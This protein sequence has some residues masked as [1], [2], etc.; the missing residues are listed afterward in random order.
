MRA[1]SRRR[2][3]ERQAQR[4]GEF[5]SLDFQLWG[6]EKRIGFDSAGLE[7]TVGGIEMSESLQFSWGV[8]GCKG[9]WA[10]YKIH[11]CLRCNVTFMMC[12]NLQLLTS[13]S[14]KNASK[15]SILNRKVSRVGLRGCWSLV[16]D[17]LG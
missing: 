3:L 10:F 13:T 11:S 12:T 2:R 5:T 8:G 16:P 14:G 17:V 6:T 7:K 1:V 4:G 9:E 15:C